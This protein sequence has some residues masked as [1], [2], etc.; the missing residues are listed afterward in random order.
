MVKKGKHTHILVIRLSAMGDV[1]MTVPV[2]RAII[3]KYP[4]IRLTILTKKNF[5]PIFDGLEHVQVKEADVKNRHKGLMG[6]WRLYKELKP[7]QFDAVA[8]LHNVLRSRILKKYFSLERVP[9]AQIDK[10]RKEKK[11]LTRSKNKVFEQLRTT[12]Q[13]YADVFGQLGFPV[14]L[15]NAK[16]LERIQ[17]SKKVLGLVG[18]DVKKWVGIAPFAAH[19]G[20]MYPLESTKEIIKKLDDTDK[21]K[22]LLFGGGI[23]EIEVL[24]GMAQ[25]SENVFCMAGKL[26]L[27]EELEL[28][29]NLDVMLSMDSGNAHMAANYG[30]PVVTLWGVTHPFAGFYPFGQPLENALMADRGIYPLIP[31]SVYGNKLPQ[32][33]ENAMETIKPE[34]VL[35]RLT[36]ILDN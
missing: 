8:D 1:A 12:H 2:L 20:K 6:L 34:Q 29:S 33:Y 10:G 19:E 13:R 14:D 26:K 18:Q 22:I 9:F 7:L 5:M 30:I 3:D 28:I 11:A 16:P 24:E 25:T 4:E 21:Y 27:S 32:G 23:K 35:D 31:T 15:S 17:L 36:G